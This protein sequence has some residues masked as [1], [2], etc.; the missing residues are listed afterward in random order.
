MSLKQKYKV[1]R[2]VKEHHKKK[3]KEL[4]KAGGKEKRPK[5]PG[6]P[7]QWPFKED[8]IKEFAFKRAQILAE[9]KRKKEEKKA[10]RQVRDSVLRDA[11]C[12]S[13]AATRCLCIRCPVS[14]LS[15][16]HAGTRAPTLFVVIWVAV[17]ATRGRARAL[18]CLSELRVVAYT[19]S[20][21]LDVLV[22]CRRQGL[23]RA[24]PRQRQQSSSLRQPPSRKTTKHANAHASL[25]TSS[26]TQVCAP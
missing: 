10:R 25:R 9:E 6:L 18:L 20:D 11:A 14:A 22:L 19:I 2:K 17:A 16:K 12:H 8:L 15:L 7:Q 13:L 23:V 3:R 24:S 5:D 21:C 4:K 1:I 26:Q